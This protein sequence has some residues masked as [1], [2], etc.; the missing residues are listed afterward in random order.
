MN[1][2]IAL[3]T[4]N[5]SSKSGANFLACDTNWLPWPLGHMMNID[6]V[7]TKVSC[8]TV[9]RLETTSLYYTQL[10]T[11]LKSGLT[12]LASLARPLSDWLWLRPLQP[13]QLFFF[14]IAG[15]FAD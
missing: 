6:I 11:I 8:F 3:Q 5:I 7:M 13:L 1:V 2:E 10:M 14:F 12:E 4:D 15:K 9:E